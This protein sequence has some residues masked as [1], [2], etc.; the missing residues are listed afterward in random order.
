LDHPTDGVVRELGLILKSASAPTQS[1]EVAARLPWGIDQ[2][3]LRYEPCPRLGQ[4]ELD[5][6]VSSDRILRQTIIATT[7][8][9]QLRFKQIYW[10]RVSPTP[11]IRAK[12]AEM[13]DFSGYRLNGPKDVLSR[14]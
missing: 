9:I 13:A 8:R 10:L 5:L 6:T 3:A 1:P 11:R 14:H 4:G 12:G 2:Q 7:E